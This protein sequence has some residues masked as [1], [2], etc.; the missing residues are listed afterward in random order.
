MIDLQR[1]SCLHLL[2]SH[3]LFSYA[4]SLTIGSLSGCLCSL[5]VTAGGFSSIS[6]LTTI[7]II[8]R[9]S[10][11]SIRLCSISHVLS[12]SRN[13]EEIFNRPVYKI[14]FLSLFFS[15]GIDDV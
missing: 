7:L 13:L 4:L 5:M 3:S 6:I 1:N 12:E 11:C 8:T 9:F 15:E 14:V 2:L 10:R